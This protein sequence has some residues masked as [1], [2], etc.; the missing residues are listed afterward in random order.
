MRS[1]DHPNEALLRIQAFGQKGPSMTTTRF[2]V[3]GYGVTGRRIA[4]AVR[5]MPDI[6]ASRCR[7]SPVRRSGTPSSIYRGMPKLLGLGY[8]VKSQ[9][10]VTFPA[11]ARGL[12]LLNAKAQP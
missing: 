10:R 3:N 6:G 2:A 1:P 9:A 11:Y 4:D 12:S 8:D 5:S 7:R